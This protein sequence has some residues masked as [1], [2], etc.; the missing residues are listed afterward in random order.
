MKNFE[1]DVVVISA[2]TAGLPAAVTAAEG[3][4][5]V[6]ICEKKGRTGGALPGGQILAVGSNAQRR[7]GITITSRELF[8][9]H[10]DYMH[11]LVDARL[12]KAYFDE[13]GPTIDWF[14]K[15]GIEFDVM[16]HPTGHY[17]IT[18][19][20]AEN[21]RPRI[22]TKKAEELGVKILL[23]TPVKKILKENG[24]ITGV[25]AEGESGEEV[26]VKAKA[27][28][29]A[30]GGFG[31]NPDMI[32]EYTGFEWGKDIFSF[33]IKGSTG[34]G[35]RM[36][37]EVG[38]AR[39]N[40]IMQVIFGLPD[41]V[42]PMGTSFDTMQFAQPN[43]LVNVMG[44]RFT[45]EDMMEDTSHLGNLISKQKDR[46]AFMIFDGATKKHYE[47]DGLDFG[48]GIRRAAQ[49]Q[50]ARSP[51]PNDTANPPEERNLDFDEPAILQ[52]GDSEDLDVIIQKWLD[53]GYEHLFMTASLEELC[54][55]TG[56]DRNGLLKTVAEYNQCCE[57]G[58][59]AVFQK[60]PKYLRPIKTPKFYAGRFFPSAY[61]SLGGIK[62][63][64]KTEVLDNEDRPI[65]G[66]Y[67]AGIDAGTIFSDT[68]TR[69]LYGNT[70][71]F[72]VTTGRIAGKSALEY[73]KNL[74]I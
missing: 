28:I 43:L 51:R 7:K 49:R 74:N 30:A 65:P 46:C 45:T 60:D 2:G 42:G 38:A 4:A 44:E 21:A 71:G 70:M 68:Y 61:G 34:D 1:T 58:Y 37:W 29:V 3:G 67:A 47:E 6:I 64:Y 57:N 25:M 17:P 35:I 15:L 72:C 14:E 52:T 69:F 36:A 9:I 16:D 41:M 54:A 53:K 66:L 24:Q 11:W 8:Q 5:R 33:R 31:D 20:A 10:M 73:V 63:N 26:Q 12:V 56:I 19:M 50:A 59:D 39:S 32:K 18:H 48:L 27:V 23:K 55:Q 22:L 62:I 40:M 13:S